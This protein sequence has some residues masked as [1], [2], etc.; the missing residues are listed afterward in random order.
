MVL[1]LLQTWNILYESFLCRLWAKCIYPPSSGAAW[2]TASVLLAKMGKSTSNICSQ[3]INMANVLSLNVQLFHL[4][5]NITIFSYISASCIHF[6]FFHIAAV[7]TSATWGQKHS[8][9]WSA[10]HWLYICTCV[11]QHLS[12][13]VEGNWGSHKH[14]VTVIYRL[15]DDITFPADSCHNLPLLLKYPTNPWRILGVLRTEYVG[16]FVISHPCFFLIYVCL[17]SA[18]TKQIEINARCLD[19]LLTYE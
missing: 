7:L 10:P 18:H 4:M 13:H 8:H 5:W 3:T 6:F 2:L 12:G 11:S 19:I 14:L 15:E 16:V 1:M 17:N 9:H